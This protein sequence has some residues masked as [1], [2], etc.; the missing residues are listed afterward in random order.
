VFT[1]GIWIAAGHR[2]WSLV[3]GTGLVMG[4]AG[5][6]WRV[7]DGYAV[8]EVTGEVDLCTQAQPSSVECGGI[9]SDSPA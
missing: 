5:F 2:L 6:G 1:L 4:G 7:E 3:G 9:A 8:V